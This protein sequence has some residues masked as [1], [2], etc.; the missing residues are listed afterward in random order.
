MHGQP[1]IAHASQLEI[2]MTH[3]TGFKSRCHAS[4]P[5][6]AG[7]DSLKKGLVSRAGAGRSTAPAYGGSPKAAITLI[8]PPPQAARPLHPQDSRAAGPVD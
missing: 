7:N 1:G 4:G 6:A 5:R 3:P 8:R 2:R